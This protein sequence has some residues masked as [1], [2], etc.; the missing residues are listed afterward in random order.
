MIIRCVASYDE[1]H[2]G[3]AEWTAYNENNDIVGK[4]PFLSLLQEELEQKLGN[5]TF[6]IYWNL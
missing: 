1:Q 5:I 3:V 4:G 6:V 2:T